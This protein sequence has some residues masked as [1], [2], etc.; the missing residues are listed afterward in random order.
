VPSVAMIEGRRK[1]RM[2]R[3]LKIPTATPTPTSGG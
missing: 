3:A 1:T 2:R